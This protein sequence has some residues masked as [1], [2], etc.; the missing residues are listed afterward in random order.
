MRGIKKSDSPILKGLQIYHNFI[1]E[2]E[3]L[4]ENFVERLRE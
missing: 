3:G 2:H 4:R 1:R